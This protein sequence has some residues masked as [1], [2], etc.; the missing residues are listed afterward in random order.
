MCLVLIKNYLN[1]SVSGTPWFIAALLSHKGI[2]K[3]IELRFFPL[4][5]GGFYEF[6]F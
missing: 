5:V 3:V 2:K 4:I 6:D 1:N